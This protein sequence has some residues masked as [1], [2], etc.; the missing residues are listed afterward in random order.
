MQPSMHST[1]RSLG[2]GSFRFLQ[3]VIFCLLAVSAL[4]AMSAAQCT[5][6]PTANN[7]TTWHNDNY[8]TGWQQVE[9]CLTPTSV[10][11]A[12]NFGLR[13][14]V[15]PLTIGRIDSQPLAVAQVEIGGCQQPNCPNVVYVA[16]EQD[17]LYA[18]NAA[19]GANAWAP[20]DPR[21][22]APALP[23]TAGP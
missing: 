22:P 20:T 23:P 3:T 14:I 5:A 11:Q 9:T 6:P 8:R 18:L 15:S 21:P 10:N 7:V 4:T 2:G 12:N 17:N 19:T 13:Y 1:L 16:D